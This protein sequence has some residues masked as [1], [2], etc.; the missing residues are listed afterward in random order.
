MKRTFSG[1][2]L[3]VPVTFFI[4]VFMSFLIG[5][6]SENIIYTITKVPNL[7]NVLVETPANK[8]TPRT[9]PEQEKLTPKPVNSSLPS[10]DPINLSH[11]DTRTSD[12]LPTIDTGFVHTEFISTEPGRQASSEAIPIMIVEPRWPSNA[13]L[14]GRVRLC[15][16]VMA[17]GRA[18][19][20]I[21]VESSPGNKFVRSAKRAVH[22]WKF[23]PSYN[24]GVAAAQPNKCYTIEYNYEG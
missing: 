23:R 24:N 18:T 12:D 15:F 6:K 2:L 21:V 16:T 3:G 8:K 19:D 17:D 4:F 7:G 5:A 9:I 11:T 1:F 22:K 10:D 20:I 14:A 13:N